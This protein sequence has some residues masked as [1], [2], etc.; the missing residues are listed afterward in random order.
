MS[1][2]TEAV[3]QKHQKLF[4]H[5]YQQIVNV[6]SKIDPDLYQETPKPVPRTIH[7]WKRTVDVPYSKLVFEKDTRL[8]VQNS[9]ALETLKI[10]EVWITGKVHKSEAVQLWK[11]LDT[12]TSISNKF[13][14]DVEEE[15]AKTGVSSSPFPDL[16]INSI[17]KNMPVG[18]MDKIHN[19]AH[20]YS[21]KIEK[22][23][24]S[25]ETLNL[26]DISQELF[27]S[28]NPSDMQ[29]MAGQFGKM[30]QDK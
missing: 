13:N 25:L 22:G 2:V 23:E 5:N 29:R 8:F 15:E 24:T 20:N 12:L 18:I 3:S 11:L 21:E 27:K 6:L 1:S 19:V 16:D 30:F 14:G 7:E 10:G 28:I 17:Y 4:A 26:G 9:S